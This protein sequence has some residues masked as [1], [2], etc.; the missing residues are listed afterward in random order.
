MEK[1]QQRAS[2]KNT[3]KGKSNQQKKEGLEKALET[4]V[5][6]VLKVRRKVIN[7]S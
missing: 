3:R 6:K 2:L 7:S 4:A 1:N 5:E